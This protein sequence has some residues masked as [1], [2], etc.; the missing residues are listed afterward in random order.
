MAKE[1]NEKPYESPR[2]PI[3]VPSKDDPSKAIEVKPTEVDLKG[4]SGKYHHNSEPEN[5]PDYQLKVID[6]DHPDAVETFGH[7]HWA[8]NQDRTWS[9]SEAD[10]KANFEKK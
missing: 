3:F 9:G 4:Y 7:T 10:F 8:K 6:A 1:T 2:K 5:F